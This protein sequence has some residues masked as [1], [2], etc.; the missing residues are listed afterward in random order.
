MSKENITI[1]DLKKI[2]GLKDLPDEHLQWLLDNS[3]LKIR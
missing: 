1:E 2:I 3:E